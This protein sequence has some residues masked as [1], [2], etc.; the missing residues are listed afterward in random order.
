MGAVAGSK[1]DMTRRRFLEAA[2]KVVAR[3]GYPKTSIAK[4]TDEAGMAS[5]SFYYYFRNRE[6]LL[7]QLLPA[8]GKELVAFIIERVG[9]M[10]WGLEREVAGFQAYFD[11]LRVRPEFYRVFTEAQVYVPAAYKTHLQWIID[12]YVHALRRQR[13]RGGLAIAESDLIGLAYTLTGIRNYATQMLLDSN[14]P[15]RPTESECIALYRRVL[16]GGLFEKRKSGGRRKPTTGASR[17]SESPVADV[18]A[19]MGP[20]MAHG[21]GDTN[22]TV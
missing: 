21:E 2:A 12:N 19:E 3:E 18:V 9:G 6:E 16:V 1:S 8:L 17:S 14:A 7:D 22:G 10:A 5:G 15:G 4:I 13:D 11:F 20:A